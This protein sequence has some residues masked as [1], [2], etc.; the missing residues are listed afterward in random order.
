MTAAH[1]LRGGRNKWR[2]EGDN[3][4]WWGG[5]ESTA[6]GGRGGGES[7]ALGGRGSGESTVLGGQGGSVAGGG[8]GC[9]ARYPVLYCR[10]RFELN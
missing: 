3:A 5:G 1:R 2:H 7:T 4:Q 8:S 9:V 6:L 10:C